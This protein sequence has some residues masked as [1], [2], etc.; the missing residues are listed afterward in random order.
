MLAQ[1]VDSGSV[2][3]TTMTKPSVVE[4]FGHL[5]WRLL[6]IHLGGSLRYRHLALLGD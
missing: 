5:C 1:L 2:H 3:I 4:A 6:Q